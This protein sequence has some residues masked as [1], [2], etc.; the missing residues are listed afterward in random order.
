M[1]VT[2]WVKKDPIYLLLIV[3]LIV[4]LLTFQDFGLTW[5]EPLFYAYADAV[6][7]AYS[8]IQ[9]FSG[10]F[11]LQNAYGPSAS[12]HMTRGPAYLLLAREPVY[13]LEKFSL[14]AASAWH[15]V[16][17]LTFLLGVFFLY[18][19]CERWM[20]PWAAFSAAALFSAQPLLW[21]HAFINPKDPPFLVFLL[22]S[23]YLGFRMVDNFQEHKRNPIWDVLLA[24][25]CLGIDST[26]RVLGPLAALIVVIYF[27]TRKPAGKAALWIGLYAVAAV[28]VMVATFPYLWENPPLRFLQVAQFMS[29]NPTGLQVLFNGQLY[30]AYDLPQRYLPFYMLF[31]LTEPVWPLFLLGFLAGIWKW[32]LLPWKNRTRIRNPQLVTLSLMLVWFLLPLAYLLIRRPP[33]YDGMRHALFILPPVFMIAGLA[34]DFFL[35]KVSLRWLNAVAILCLLSPGIYAAIQL[36]PYEY[37]YFNSLVGGTRGV[38]RKY[39]TDYWLTCYKEA[40]QDLDRTTSQPIKLYVHREPEVAAPY[41]SPN[42]T[43]LDERGALNQIQSGDYILVNTRSNEDIRDFRNAP[44]VLSV[45]RAGATFCVIKK[46]P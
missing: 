42:V 32:I 29:D 3:L 7:Y 18:R 28:A 24:A 43:V 30:R 31:T 15:L 9:W 22:G 4:G 33:L 1:S 46:V 21:G 13:L 19:L 35:E 40:V 25:V 26:I 12:D 2:A 6:G 11:D 10:H 5:D 45:G 17:F 20:Q 23:V 27:L 36:H 37:T 41:A 39:E 38:F 8:P 16:N 34:F 44:Q 14:D